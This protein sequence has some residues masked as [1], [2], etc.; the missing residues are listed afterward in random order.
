MQ[1]VILAGGRA[2][3]MGNLTQDTPKSMLPVN[4]RPFLEHQLE[5]LRQHGITEVVLCVGHLA[6]QIKA[7]FGDG[8]RFGMHITYSEEQGRLLGTGGALKMAEPLLE[9]EFLLM[10]G[11]SYLLLDYLRIMADFRRS[12]KPGM[13]VAYKNNDYYDCSNCVLEGSLVKVYDKTRKAPEMSYIDAGL[14]A[15]KRST[16]SFFDPGEEA[17]LEDLYAHLVERKEL[18]AFE[19]DQRFYEIGSKAGIEELEGIFRLGSLQP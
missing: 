12:G 5:L 18:L 13:M 10:Y 17:P 16:L 8:S 3:R 19:T 7:Y 14:S 2:K 15:L 11:D 9:E 4:G 1:M 6:D